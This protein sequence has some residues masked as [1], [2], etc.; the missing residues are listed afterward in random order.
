MFLAQFRYFKSKLD[1]NCIFFCE[2]WIE[3]HETEVQNM[4]NIDDMCKFICEVLLLCMLD[5]V[6]FDKAD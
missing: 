5:N 4:G 1:F 6:S 3:R 2:D